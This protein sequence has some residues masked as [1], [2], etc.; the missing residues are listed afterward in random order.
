MSH[1]ENIKKWLSG[2]LSDDERRRFERTKE[3]DEIN[4]LLGAVKHFKAPD[5]DIQGE[6]SRL[7]ENVMGHGRKVSLYKRMRPVLKVAAVFILALTA[8]YFLYFYVLPSSGSPQWISSQTEVYLPDSS[9]VTL[10][11]AS[12]IRFSGKKWEKE[13]NV[14]LI[15][16][17]FFD[18]KEGVQFKVQTDQGSVAVLGTSFS[19]KDRED[20]YEVTCFS[21]S[22]RVTTSRKSVVLRPEMTYRELPGHTQMYVFSDQPEPTWINEESSF[23]SVPLNH[24]LDELERQYQVT[25][26]AK[27]VDVTRLFSGSFSHEN[28]DIALQAVTI[29]LDLHYEIIDNKIVI[30]VEGK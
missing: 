23:R 2:E 9:L 20:Y 15:G 4:K 24:V 17:A 25:V 21:G 1:E 7:S 12:S 30:T 11:A 27:D 10:N 22:V 19:V 5:F 14:E 29:P 18:V 26:E 3:F 13:R 28:L 16:E 6:Y 8:G